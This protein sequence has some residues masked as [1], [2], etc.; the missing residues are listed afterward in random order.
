MMASMRRPPPPTMMQLVGEA[1][2]LRQD[3]AIIREELKRARRQAEHDRDKPDCRIPPATMT[4]ALAVY[5]LT[6]YDADRAAAFLRGCL[7]SARGRHRRARVFDDAMLR[8]LVDNKFITAN[9]EYIARLA[10][11]RGELLPCQVVARRFLMRANLRCYVESLNADRGIAPS[12]ARVLRER[13]A[14]ADGSYLRAHPR[15]LPPGDAA[16]VKD[17]VW[18]MRWRRQS[19]IG[20]GRVRAKDWMSK[21][22]TR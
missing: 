10:D 3:A 13:I 5:A 16:H 1:A 2:R 7:S 6:G 4:A 17:R 12:T 19:K 9:S 11:L 20:L 15:Q 22:E 8:R 14:L 18:A 21:E